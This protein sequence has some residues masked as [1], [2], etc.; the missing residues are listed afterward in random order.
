[1]VVS[2]DQIDSYDRNPRKAPNE[3]FEELKESIGL[4]GLR[5]PLVITRRPGAAR[6]MPKHGGNT[7]LVILKE[8]LAAGW[9][10]L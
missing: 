8:L 6:Y 2:V 1:M 10:L 9:V 3:K 7:R 5:Q 4:N